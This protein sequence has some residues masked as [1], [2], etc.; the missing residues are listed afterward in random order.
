[1][2]DA[3]PIPAVFAP[4]RHLRNGPKFADLEMHHFTPEEMIWLCK[5]ILNEFQSSEFFITHFFF[6]LLCVVGHI[7]RDKK[8]QAHQF[9]PFANEQH[10]SRNRKYQTNLIFSIIHNSS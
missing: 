10:Y 9:D 8:R 4:I 3:D 6:F 1:V 2:S 5:T 7:K